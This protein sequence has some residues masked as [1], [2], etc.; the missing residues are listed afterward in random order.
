M[1]KTKNMC[2]FGTDEQGLQTGTVKISELH[3]FKGHPFKV[4][5]DIQLFELMRSIE[6]KGVLVPLLVRSNPYG[7]GY[8]IIAGHRRKAACEWAGIDEVPVIVREMDDADAVIAMID[9]NLQ[10]EHIKPS[11]KAFAYKMKLEAMK[12]QG[13]RTDL[14][15]SQVG[16]KLEKEQ[17]EDGK[18]ILRADERLAKEVGESRNQI[19]RYIRLTN[20]IPK[21]LD[22]VDE[23]KIA[24][25]IG[26]ELSYLSEG[27]QYELRAVMDLEGCTPSLSQANRLKRMSQSGSLDMDEMYRILEQEKPNQREQIKIRADT[28]AEYFPKDYTPRQ[29]VELIETLVK[30]WHEKQMEQTKTSAQQK[31]KRTE[32]SSR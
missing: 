24:F 31:L 2:S 6:D 15:S 19:A 14:T 13:K 12:S 16:T 9:S 32:R 7:D 5:N 21:I 20:L 18:T 3:E 10:R 28:L 1:E 25:T 4:E 23:G 17:T 30:E 26:V 11:E 29:K 8:E 22:M 27:E